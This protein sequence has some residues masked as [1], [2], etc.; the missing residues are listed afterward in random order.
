MRLA[1]ANRYATRAPPLLPGWL[2]DVHEGRNG[3]ENADAII[4]VF[5]GRRRGGVGETVEVNPP[6]EAPAHT[7]AR[8]AQ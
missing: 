7:R 4:D 8:P 3:Q 6:S 5:I 2:R 1:Y